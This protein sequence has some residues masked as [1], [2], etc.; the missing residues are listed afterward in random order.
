LLSLKTH[1]LLSY[2]H[3]LALLAAHRALPA[4]S[5]SL[6]SHTP[7]ARP[8]SDP[9]RPAR[10]TNAGDLVDVCIERRIVLEKI[11]ILES[12]MRYQMDKLVKLA[13]EDEHSKADVLDG[14]SLPS[15]LRC[16]MKFSQ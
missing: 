12:R 16:L 9:D 4:P 3:A 10:G 13:H 15:S 7:P 8:F 11:K 14:R 1:T 5:S 2:V 6:A